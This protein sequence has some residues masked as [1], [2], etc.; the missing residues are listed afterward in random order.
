MFFHQGPERRETGHHETRHGG[1]DKVHLLEGE[2]DRL[3]QTVQSL[4]AALKDVTENLRVDLKEDTRKT[5]VTLLNNMRPPDSAT[6]AGTDDSPAVLDGQAT[7]GAALG[8]KALE[9]IMVRLDDISSNLKNKDEALEDLR[10]TMSSHEGQ[11]RVLMDASQ[12]PAIADFD[13]IQA[14]I[15]KNFEKMKKELD[16]NMEEHIAKL[17]T[18]CDDRISN[19]QK[20]CEDSRDQGLVSLTKLVDTKEA[21]LRKEMREIRREMAATDTPIRTQRQTDPAKPE[22]DHSSHK[23]LWREIDRIATAHR[24][25][26]MRI[27]NELL[28]ISEPPENSEINLLIEDLEARVNISEQNAET[29]CFYIEQKLTRTVTD[30]AVAL[31][32]L[33]EDRLNNMKDQ[34]T[35]MLVE[36]SNSSFPGMFSIDALQAEVNSNKFHLQ[37]LDDRLNVVA[38]LCST[39]CPGSDRPVG[40]SAT[41]RGLENILKDMSRNRNEFEVLLNDVNAN[42]DKLRQLEDLVER[43][44]VAIN[45]RD[46]AMDGFQKGLIRLQDNV[47]GLGGAVTG[48]SDSVH[49]SNQNVERI[50]STCC[51]VGQSG[52]GSPV[53]DSWT[54]V[55]HH[56]VDDTRRQVEDLRRRLDSFSVRLSSGIGQCKENTQGVS[57]NM[58]EVDGRVSRL[59]KVCG[60]LDMVS[61]NIKELKDGLERNIGGLR[62]AVHNMNTTCGNQAADIDELRNSLQRLEEDPSTLAK[63]GSAAK[64]K[65]ELLR[66]HSVIPGFHRY[67]CYKTHRLLSGLTPEPDSWIPTKNPNNSQTD[68]LT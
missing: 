24:I 33:M 1:T 32:Q 23:D 30:E 49:K 27:D 17:Q 55:P 54:S 35:N 14:Y 12:T 51:P 43:Q 46:S 6:A 61:T 9:K 2:V 62:E 52:R 18:T 37:G 5:L 26:N 56:Q 10:G 48:L 36:M 67:C 59:E 41:I 7:K 39:G 34:F 11:I 66:E 65:G 38:E 25:L 29:H 13:V 16:Q 45:R 28:H 15:D 53:R 64:D 40:S 57:V 22:E 42:T 44:S 8:D 3:S 21:D 4:Q 20:T 50:N 19:L 68:M 58:S 31:R 63:Q 60:R 47:L